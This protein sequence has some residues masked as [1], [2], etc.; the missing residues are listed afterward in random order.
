MLSTRIL[1]RKHLPNDYVLLHIKLVTLSPVDYFTN[2]I[3]L[4]I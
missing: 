2:P 3:Y 1:G 4:F